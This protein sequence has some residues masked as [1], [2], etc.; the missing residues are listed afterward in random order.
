MPN[1]VE[2]EL[3]EQEPLGTIDKLSEIFSS[4]LAEKTVHIAIKRPPGKLFRM[5][6]P[7]DSER[8]GS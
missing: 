2:T 8:A 6:Y 4:G 5:I 7:K 1:G 3:C